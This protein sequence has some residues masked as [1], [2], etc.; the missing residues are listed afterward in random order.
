MRNIMQ[1]SVQLAAEAPLNM[2]S[3]SLDRLKSELSPPELAN[4]AT[5]VIAH[6]IATLRDSGQDGAARRILIGEIAELEAK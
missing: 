6:T 3:L 4:V 1:P 5:W 2:I